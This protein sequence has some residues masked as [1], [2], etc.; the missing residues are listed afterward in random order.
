MMADAL[1]NA[2]TQGRRHRGLLNKVKDYPGIYG[3]VTWTAGQNTTASR[4]TG[5]HV[6]G[7][8]AQGRRLQ[9][10]RPGYGAA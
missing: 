7:Q 9:P 1:K 4:P 5:R 10:A 2:G 6:R 3:T 8:L